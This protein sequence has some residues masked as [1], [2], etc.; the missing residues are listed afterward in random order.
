MLRNRHRKQKARNRLAQAAKQAK[1]LAQQRAKA[2]GAGSGDRAPG[3]VPA[4]T[5]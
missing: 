3:A 5:R 1:K 2:T 4:A